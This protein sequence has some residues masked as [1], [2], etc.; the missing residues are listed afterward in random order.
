MTRLSEEKGQQAIAVVLRY[1]ALLSALVMTLGLSLIL[2]HGLGTPIPTQRPIRLGMLFLKLIHFDP[3]ALVEF[4]ILLLLLTPIFR[5]V[6]AAVTFAIEGDHKYVF[7]SM[8]V[9]A[10]VL[11]SI[12]FAIEG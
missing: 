1:G 6:V 11:L 8:C 10:V 2:L 7:I 5:V 9:L 12:S 4:G 3:V